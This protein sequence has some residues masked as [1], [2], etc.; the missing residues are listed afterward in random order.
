MKIFTL[1]LVL[2]LSIVSTF[3]CA[4]SA[5][6]PTGE[7]NNANGVLVPTVLQE[8]PVMEEVLHPEVVVPKA[9]AD[10]DDNWMPQVLVKDN[11][12]TET[13]KLNSDFDDSTKYTYNSS[14]VAFKTVAGALTTQ[15]GTGEFPTFT[16]TAGNSMA[17]CN[18]A[19]APFPYGT[20]SC[21]VKT[22]TDTDSGIVFGL[23]SSAPSYWEGAGIGYYFFFL[24][25]DGTAYLGK[26]DNGMWYVVNIVDYS[27]NSV[28]TY[29][30]KV[31]FKGTTIYCY[32]NND[33]MFAVRDTAALKGTGFGVRSGAAGVVFS[34]LTVTNDY[35]Y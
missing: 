32:V 18:T 1:I 17:V 5:G 26:T 35:N 3:G 33:L 24:G 27:F 20:I 14:T 16:T 12:P 6:Q 30:L 28:D 34:N 29:N 4:A 22:V 19:Q 2:A 21:D 25:R 10:I 11:D 9:P 23:S 8:A 7:K 13:D 31:V 15:A